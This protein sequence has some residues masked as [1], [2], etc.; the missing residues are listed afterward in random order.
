MWVSAAV[1]PVQKAQKVEAGLLHLSANLHSARKVPEAVLVPV[2]CAGLHVHEQN[3][4]A[5]S[6][7]MHSLST[8]CFPCVAVV[9]TMMAVAVPVP[10]ACTGRHRHRGR[11]VQS[12][13]TRTASGTIPCCV[14]CTETFRGRVSAL[15][16][17]HH[18]S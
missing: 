3:A 8:I 6:R 17:M 15:I 5:G 13:D 2:A 10:V 9:E 18:T 12:A 1:L 16:S 14:C 7:H 11:P 4:N